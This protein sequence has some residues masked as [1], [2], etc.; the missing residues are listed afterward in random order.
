MS[1][2]NFDKPYLLFVLLGILVVII[3]SFLLSVNG[4]NRTKGNMA[5]FFIHISIAILVSLALAKTT[6][7]KVIT[8]TDIYVLADVSYSSNKNLDLIDEY[9]SNLEKNSPKNSK[10]G[11]I[12]FGKDQELLVELGEKLR[13][14]KEAKV[15]ESETDI[16][17][18]LEYAQSLFADNVIKH[19]V[20]ISD[21]D[22]TNESDL[23][24]LVQKLSDEEIYVDAIYLDNN[25]KE[26]EKEVQIDSIDY[27][28]STYLSYNENLNVYIQSNTEIRAIITLKCDGQEYASTA[29]TF[30]KG[31]NLVSFELNTEEAGEHK[32]EVSVS[33]DGD[34]NEKNN[35]VSF[36]QKV[37]QQTKVLFIGSS[38]EDKE[39][40]LQ[41]YS[42]CDITFFINNN[43]VPFTVEELCQYDEFVLSNIDIRELKN[44]SQFISSV[45]TLVSE[46]G[47]SLV[48]IGNTYIQNNEDDALLTSLGDMLP[49]KYGNDEKKKTVTIVLDI[50]RSMEQLGRLII[51]RKAACLILDK[52]EDDV[53][54][55]C[56]VFYGNVR[57]LFVN[58]SASDRNELKDLINKVEPQQ[59]TFL[60]A[61]LQYT[62][63]FISSF[64]NK[65]NEVIL[66]SDGLPY[67]EQ[68]QVS[69]NYANLIGET[70]TIISTIQTAT[71]DVEAIQLMKDIANAGNGY[72]H[73]IHEV[74]EVE[75]TIYNEVFN[76]LN[77]TVLENQNLP[78]NILLNKDKFVEG[79]SSLPSIRG[80]YN[81][82]AKAS[83]KV[84]MEAVYTDINDIKYNIPLYTYWSYGNGK[85]SSFASTISGEWMSLWNG[86]NEQKVLSNIVE[87]NV[88]QQRTDSAFIIECNNKGTLADIIVKAPTL[89]KDSVLTMKVTYP[90]GKVEEKVLAS[91]IDANV[92]KYMTEISTSQVGEYLFE[93]SYVLKDQYYSANYLYNVSYLPEYDSF[94][95]YEAS[96]LYYMVSAN[97][98][99]S[100]DGNLVLVNDLSNVQKYV[101]DFTPIFMIIASILFVIDIIVRKLRLQDIIS[102]W[103]KIIRK[104]IS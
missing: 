26:N 64:D 94:T 24:S 95:I 78:V 37:T 34:G 29:R 61:A 32:Y 30:Q 13:S 102:L 35:V 60:G 59:G 48:T 55:S 51:A 41:L 87:T 11:V 99:V 38:N 90:N 46:F 76:S 68:A 56:I 74:D 12:C 79:V 43:D 72:Y 81:N 66:I 8:E 63:N 69:R 1:N 42:D 96:N 84:V 16:A 83:S 19:I 21:G 23:T 9:I 39:A 49:T 17:S 80:L 5:S 2:V 18:A 67:R 58:K 77:E 97:G 4:E 45:N 88:P 3:I 36:V 104:K 27:T 14:V 89:N 28:P 7:E 31:Y 92:Q 33:V 6:Y 73:Y 20:I 52:L 54:V 25:L 47:K 15:D 10:I 93:L 22:E 101:I 40:A 50:S 70:G 44:N 100:E 53:T 82:T 98:Q 86:E 62:Y 75:D 103:N 71:S 85:V 91:V 65:K 57:N